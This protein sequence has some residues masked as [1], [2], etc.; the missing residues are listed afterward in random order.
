MAKVIDATGNACPKPVMITKKALDTDS[1]IEVLVDN[2]TAAKNVTMF[3]ASRGCTV[4]S[5]QERPNLFRVHIM[6]QE[7]ADECER[8]AAFA[9]GPT[10]FVFS[11]DVMGRGE[12][13]LGKVLIKAFLHTA[14]ELDSLPD[15]MLFYNT[16]VKLAAIDAET[17]ADIKVL[18]DKGVKILVC[19]TCVNYFNLGGKLAAGTVSNMYDIL[20][21]MNTAG[22]IVT[23]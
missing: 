7:G 21:A 8:I 9:T 18:E 11:S 23:P 13:A 19:G 14:T 16:G 1:D 20:N 15:M 5:A 12:E 3:A 17:A 10:V 4:S 6:K 2:E 22:R